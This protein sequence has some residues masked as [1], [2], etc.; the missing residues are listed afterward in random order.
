MYLNNLKIFLSVN[1]PSASIKFSLQKYSHVKLI[2]LDTYNREIE[3]L[4]NRELNAGEYEIPCDKGKYP[5]GE[6]YYRLTA[7]EFTETKK[8]ILMK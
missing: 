2:V 1:D 5:V 3:Q 8:M 4:I 6:Y 7:G